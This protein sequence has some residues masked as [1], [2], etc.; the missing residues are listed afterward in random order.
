MDRN[1]LHFSEKTIEMKKLL[2]AI[3]IAFLISSCDVSEEIKLP[4]ADQIAGEYTVNTFTLRGQKIP[5]PINLGGESLAIDM[6]VNKL[7]ESLV[8]VQVITKSTTNG[9][10]SESIDKIDNVSLFEALD[11]TIDL[12]SEN[13]RLG[14]YAEGS[15]TFEIEQNGEKSSFSAVRKQ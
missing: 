12:K 4:L 5:L 2:T 6:T 11:G 13:E 1:L 10:T 14:F 9:N 8:N 3:S 7:S 15:I